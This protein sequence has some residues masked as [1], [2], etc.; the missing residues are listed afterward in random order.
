MG[1]PEHLKL[2]VPEG[3]PELL[4][5]LTELRMAQAYRAQHGSS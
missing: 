4:K 2:Q 1:V 3:V 5:E